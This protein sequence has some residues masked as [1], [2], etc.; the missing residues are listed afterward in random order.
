MQFNNNSFKHARLDFVIQILPFSLLDFPA[1][2][3]LQM[4]YENQANL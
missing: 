2:I 4:Y 3:N 1:V